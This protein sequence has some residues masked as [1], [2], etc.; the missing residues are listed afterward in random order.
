[1]PSLFIYVAAG[2]FIIP[3]RY[4]MP[5]S[6]IYF[7]SITSTVWFKHRTPHKRKY[8]NRFPRPKP[9]SSHCCIGSLRGT[10]L[11]CLHLK[12]NTSSG[13]L[14][15][16]KM[17]KQIIQMQLTHPTISYLNPKGNFPEPP[18]CSSQSVVKSR[19]PKGYFPQKTSFSPA[20]PNPTG[21]DALLVSA[22]PQ[23]W[24][25]KPLHLQL[26]A[27]EKRDRNRKATK[28]AAVANASEETYSKKILVCWHVQP[29]WRDL[30]KGE[31]P[32]VDHLN[33]LVLLSLCAC[34]DVFNGL[35]KRRRKLQTEGRTPNWVPKRSSQRTGRPSED[36]RM[37]LLRCL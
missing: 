15:R 4:L 25:W 24:I 17:T 27:I 16:L 6:L 23:S 9:C 14:G 32:Y 29:T 5:V 19:R 26:G 1:M 22:D 11:R 36:L 35:Q 12:R 30:I 8:G 37:G 28:Q 2:V 33:K 31:S 21:L 18:G 20:Q 10:C 34:M 13:F 3:T 7:A